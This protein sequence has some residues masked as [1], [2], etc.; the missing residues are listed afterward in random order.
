[1]NAPANNQ[2]VPLAANDPTGERRQDFQ[3]LVVPHPE[4][5][6]TLR[7]VVPSLDGTGGVAAHS[8]Q[9]RVTLQKADDRIVG[10]Q[11]HC[12]CGQQID[13]SCSYEASST[14]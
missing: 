13:L 3:V 7:E 5:V 10:I 4:N 14:P 2:F 12:S 11:I 1:M 6:R 8:C 9:P